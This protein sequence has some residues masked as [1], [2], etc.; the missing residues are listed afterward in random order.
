MMGRRTANQARLVCA[1]SLDKRIPD[2]HLLRRIDVFVTEALA[3]VHREM[4]ASYSQTG[5]P[6]IDP[7]LLLRMLIVGYG[8]GV[9][10]E[11]R[12]SEEVSLM[13]LRRLSGARDA[14]LLAAVAQNLKRLVRLTA[15]SV[16]AA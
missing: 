13:R 10:P 6:S 3:D 16:A 11:R 1:F 12:L 14:F 8:Y 4:T 15:P 5:R 2:T 7:E 9:R